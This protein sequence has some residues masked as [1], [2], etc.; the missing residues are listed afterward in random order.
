MAPAVFITSTLADTASP[1]LQIRH[2]FLHPSCVIKID[3]INCVA[4]E[5]GVYARAAGQQKPV[6]ALQGAGQH[7]T[8]KTLEKTVGDAD[9]QSV[10]PA[11][12][13]Q[14]YGFP[15]ARGG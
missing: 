10:T 9:F 14:E 3:D 5:C 15:N 6:G 12:G 11:A 7:K 8:C 2:T 1:R 4:Q 13:M